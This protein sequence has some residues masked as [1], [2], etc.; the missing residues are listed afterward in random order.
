[1]TD[2]ATG[3]STDSAVMM[4]EMP[5]GAADD[6]S[7]N[8]AFSFGSS[9]HTGKR[10]RQDGAAKDHS[11]WAAASMLT[12]DQFAGACFRSRPKAPD[13]YA[14]AETNGAALD[15]RLTSATPQ[16]LRFKRQRD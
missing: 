8:A 16:S 12:A 13:K 10:S 15:E 5:G 3:C 1:M 6:C 4:S 2:G 9:G 11:H 7:F 14:L